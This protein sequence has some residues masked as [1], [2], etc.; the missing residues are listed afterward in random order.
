MGSDTQLFLWF[1]VSAFGLLMGN[2]LRSKYLRLQ[3]HGQQTTGLV[4]SVMD[5][6]WFTFFD[7]RGIYYHSI[8]FVTADKQWVTKS[9]W[10]LSS[11]DEDNYREGQQVDILYNPANPEEFT[12][13]S[14]G[15]GIAA[16]LLLLSGV[17]GIG[18]CFWLIY[19]QL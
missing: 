14:S 18:Y 2:S 4:T 6:T 19:Q 5:D 12:V 1:I 3:A 17:A 16:Y 9:Y 7:G 11:P 13:N 10:Q 15:S 8:R